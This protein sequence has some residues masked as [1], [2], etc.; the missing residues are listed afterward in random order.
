MVK[1]YVKYAEA[2]NEANAHSLHTTHTLARPMKIFSFERNSV[3]CLRNMQ[4]LTA[5]FVCIW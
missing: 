2:K 5:N 1:E 3:K 4:M